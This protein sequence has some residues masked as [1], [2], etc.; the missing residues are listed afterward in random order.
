MTTSK[1]QK[2]Y[3]ISASGILYV[4][5]YQIFMENEDTGEIIN[6][7]DLLADFSSRDCQITV[8][9]DENY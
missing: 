2:Q 5:N 8:T 4:E 6:L 7:A 1:F 3:K 9:C